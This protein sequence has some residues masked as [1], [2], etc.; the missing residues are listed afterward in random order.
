MEEDLKDCKQGGVGF[1]GVA[2]GKEPA[3]Q[4]GSHKRHEFEL[5][6]SR[7]RESMDRGVWQATVHTVTNSQT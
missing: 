4:H 7:V 6:D 1:L 3:C 5:M 2:S